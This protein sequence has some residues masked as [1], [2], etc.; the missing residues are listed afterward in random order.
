MK[1][2]TK[3][4]ALSIGIVWASGILFASLIANAF[5]IWEQGIQTIATFYIGYDTT[6]I[7]ALIGALYGFIDGFVGAYAVAWLYNKLS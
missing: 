1:L 2:S 7:G 4:F 3:A 5:G 6:F